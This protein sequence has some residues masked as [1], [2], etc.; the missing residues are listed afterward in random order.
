[1]EKRYF[2]GF[3]R[4]EENMITF[5]K[6]SGV[7]RQGAGYPMPVALLFTLVGAVGDGAG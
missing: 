4:G 5:Y 7:C 1:M 6:Q 2:T 3:L